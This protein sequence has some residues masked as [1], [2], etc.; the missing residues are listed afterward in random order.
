[1]SDIITKQS[2]KA[3]FEEIERIKQRLDTFYFKMD[4][5]DYDASDAE[6]S[7]N[8]ENAKGAVSSASDLL[9]EALDHLR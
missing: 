8:Y 6:L 1:M 2:I 9:T 5:A 3:A 7:A 4:E